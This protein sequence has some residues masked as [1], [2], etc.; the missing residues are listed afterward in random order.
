MRQLTPRGLTLVEAPLDGLKFQLQ[1]E[2]HTQL[3][4]T[5]T[6]CA[7][8]WCSRNAARDK[9][10]QKQIAAHYIT[11]TGA[12]LLALLTPTLPCPVATD[13]A[14]TLVKQQRRSR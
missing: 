8:W 10:P 14:A 1:S 13:A 9:A 4:D 5:N 7:N 2:P 3:T 12:Q 6:V 11:G